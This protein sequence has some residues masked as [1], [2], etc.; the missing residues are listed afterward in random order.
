MLTS[1]VALLLAAAV[2]STYD[3]IDLGRSMTRD[4]RVLANI[5]GTNSI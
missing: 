1:I 3:L 2:Y 4:L 5:I